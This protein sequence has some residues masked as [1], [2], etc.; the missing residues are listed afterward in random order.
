MYFAIAGA[1]VK[2]GD[3]IPATFIKP[4]TF[5]APIMKSLSF[6]SGLNPANVLTVYDKSIFGT[7]FLD[8]SYT[9]FNPS[10]VVSRFSF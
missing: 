2:P 9:S 1:A 4:H 8:F 5:V 7:S 10:R 3:L 6:V